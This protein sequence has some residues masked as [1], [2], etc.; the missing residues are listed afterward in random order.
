MAQHKFMET[1]YHIHEFLIHLNTFNA[2]INYDMKFK[3]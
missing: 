1:T 3:N 2:I